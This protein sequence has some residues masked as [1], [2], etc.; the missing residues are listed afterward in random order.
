L[1][2][3]L[4]SFLPYA[5]AFA[6][7]PAF[8]TL[9]LPARPWPAPWAIAAA[10]LM[11]TGAYF[12]N[13]LPDLAIDAANGVEG[14]AHRIG[15]GGSLTVAALL[16]GSAT[17]VLAVSAETPSMLTSVLVAAALVAAGAVLVAGLAGRLR[18]AWSLTLTTAAFNV[19]IVLSRGSG[20]GA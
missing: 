6:L 7:L 14:M 9:G 20:L 11:G 3:T 1:R 19:A 15:H 4:A 16:M 17:V 12:I 18:L 10:G 8:I 2:G 13:T 5:V